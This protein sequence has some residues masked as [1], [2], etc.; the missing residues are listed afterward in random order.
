MAVPDGTGES[1]GNSVDGDSPVLFSARPEPVSFLSRYLLSFTPVV[2]AILSILVREILDSLVPAASHMLPALS[3]V[4][5]PAASNISS[6]AMAQ[7]M[8]LMGFS[9]AGFGEIT[10]IL[11]LLITPVSIFQCGPVLP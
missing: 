3:P 7:Y 5:S 6:E 9:T 1:T 10:T 11:I 8:G 4:P 2:L